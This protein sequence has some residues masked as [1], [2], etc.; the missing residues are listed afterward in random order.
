VELVS[1]NNVLKVNYA[2]N[3]IDSEEDARVVIFLPTFSFSVSQP[4][5]SETVNRFSRNFVSYAV[6]GRPSAVPF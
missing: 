3:K 4:S 5:I 6:G 1:C 2:K